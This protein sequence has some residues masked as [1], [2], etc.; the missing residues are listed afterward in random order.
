MIDD[1][2]LLFTSETPHDAPRDREARQH[3]GQS[4]KK[5]QMASDAGPD[6]H[7][8]AGAERID[9]GDRN[10]GCGLQGACGRHRAES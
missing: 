10:A 5:Q 1:R 3:H 7:P 9:G 2:R 6:G 8:E 4:E